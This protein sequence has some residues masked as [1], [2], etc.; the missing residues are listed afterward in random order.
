[1]VWFYFIILVL[2]WGSSFILIKNG[3]KGYTVWESATIRLVS[4][5]SVM[6]F[7]AIG[8]LKKIPRKKIPLVLLV[9]LLNMFFPSYLFSMAESHISSAMAGIL[10]A[11]TP[12]F[13]SVIALT[14]FGK[15]IS[16]VQ[17]VGLAIGFISAVFLITINSSTLF[18]LNEYALL[19]IVATISY[20][21]NYNIIK[22][23]LSGVKSVYITTVSVSF[24]GLLG[25]CVLFFSG[26]E[27]YIE[28][29]ENK[30]FPLLS[31][32][33][34]GVLGTSFALYIQNLLIQKS[35]AVFA[36]SVN[37]LIPVVAVL[38]G[39]LDGER[40][41]FLHYLGMLGILIGVLILNK[42]IKL[43]FSSVGVRDIG[44]RNKS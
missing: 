23:C 30:V 6:I 44:V 37:Y 19:I 41:V 35:S 15:C 12:M 20:G 38:W 34:L 16:K 11:L 31:L 5:L 7:F 27:S 3:L 36:S 2:I 8:H 25:M 14:F 43:N 33:I 28:V 42:S 21:L 22:S 1:M 17:W 32:V 10:N 26:Y 29:G 24:A 40:L 13:T 39:V 18:S 4:A 9:G